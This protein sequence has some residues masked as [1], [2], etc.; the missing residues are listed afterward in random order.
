MTYEWQP[1]ETIPKNGDWIIVEFDPTGAF[2]ICDNLLDIGM[3]IVSWSDEARDW[4][5]M[6]TD[7]R[8]VSDLNC[9]PDR[10]MPLPT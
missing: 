4:I 1:L 10:W 5:V 2:G 8:L 6:L 7:K 3:A 9:I